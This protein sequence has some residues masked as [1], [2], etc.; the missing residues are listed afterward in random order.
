MKQLWIATA[1]SLVLIGCA[2]IGGNENHIELDES[3]KVDRAVVKA[4]P[5]NGFADYKATSDGKP[6]RV[7]WLGCKT[8]NAKKSFVVI[9]RDTAEFKTDRFCQSWIAQAFVSAGYDVIGVNRPGMGQTMPKNNDFSGKNSVAAVEAVAN[10]SVNKQKF[11]P[12]TGIWAYDSGTIAAG[13]AAKKLKGIDWLIL[14]GGIYDAEIFYNGNEGAIK[15]EFEAAA[16]KENS[17]EKFE[18]RSLSWD[19]AGLPPNLFLYHG[20][21]D[22]LVSWQQTQV[23]SDAL[24]SQEYNVKT[25]FLDDADHEI[26]EAVHRALLEG[27]LRGQSRD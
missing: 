8:A 9:N 21:K 3:S 24:A 19:P 13:F 17:A 26:P 11:P 7:E 14:G 1:V 6:A 18:T 23:F 10:Y 22:T 12:I 16:A 25:Q 2:S 15:K 5:S 27:V 4:E 20:K